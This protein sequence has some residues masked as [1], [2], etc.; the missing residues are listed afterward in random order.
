MCNRHVIEKNLA[1]PDHPIYER[2]RL[3][4]TVLR[5]LLSQPVAGSRVLD[6]GCGTGD[7]GLMLASEGAQATFLDLS[8]VAMRLVLRRAR[9]SGVEHRVRAVAG[10]ASNL[11]CFADGEF[12]LI[13]ASAA[14]HHT[15]KYP[16]ALAELVRVLRPGGKLV[17]AETYGN[18]PLLNAA[19]RIRWVLC[20]E[21]AEAGEEILFNDAHITALSAC[22]ECVQI[23]PMGLMAMAKRV[24]RG[25][26]RS[27]IVRQFINCLERF[28]EVLLRLKPSLRRSCGRR[29]QAVRAINPLPSAFK[30]PAARRTVRSGSRRCRLR[31][32]W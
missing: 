1:N 4:G 24:F 14:I 29:T 7:W 6:Y 27:L 28:D 22:L 3:Y 9:V 20:R 5:V 12:D 23:T 2:R 11:S 21:P 25:R 15:L 32:R 13:Y 8:D 17:I 19:R 30:T 26:F 18:N 10:D 31:G 16:N